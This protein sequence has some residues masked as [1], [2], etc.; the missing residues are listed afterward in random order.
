MPSRWHSRGAIIAVLAAVLVSG[1]GG[2]QNATSHAPVVRVTERDFKISAPKKLASGEIV[3]RAHNEGPDEHE[4][5]VARIGALGLPLRTDGLTLNEEALQRSEAGAL[6]PG[7]PGSQRE[8]DVKLSPGRYVFFCNMA[9][10]YMGGMHAEVV[11]Q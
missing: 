9:G 6:E 7:A 2:E 4:L 3:L 11:V 8:L 1:C 10:H 5:I